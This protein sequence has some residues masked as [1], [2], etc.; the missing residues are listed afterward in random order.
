MSKEIEKELVTEEGLINELT[1]NEVVEI[2][3]EIKDDNEGREI[4]LTKGS[5]FTRILSGVLDQAILIG[6]AALLE[7]VFDL[8]LRL[9]G[10]MVV[11]YV[12]ILLIIFF[13]VNCIYSPIMERVKDGRTFGKRIMNII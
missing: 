9:V 13:M 2:Q 12:P 6:V 3:E 7:V 1:E 4:T 8:I 11:D 10:F 5:L